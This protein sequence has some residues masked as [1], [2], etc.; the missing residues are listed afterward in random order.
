MYERID[1]A[2][3]HEQKTALAKLSAKNIGVKRT[4]RGTDPAD[5]ITPGKP[6]DGAAIGGV[7]VVSDG[8]LVRGAAVGDGRGLQDLRGELPWGGPFEEDSTGSS[9]DCGGKAL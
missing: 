4:R 6:G 7:K 5:L 2:A 3:T 1:A 8:G 9:G